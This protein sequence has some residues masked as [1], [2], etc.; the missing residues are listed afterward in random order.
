MSAMGAARRSGVILAALVALGG[1]A[2]VGVMVR[3]ALPVDETRYLAVAWE[4]WRGGDYLTPHLNGA[5]YSHKPPLLFWLI[6]LVWAAWGEVS[7]V[8]ARLVAPGFGLASLLLVWRLS[9]ALWP[10]ARDAAAMAPWVLATTGAFLVFASLTTF[11]AMLTAATLLALLALVWARRGGGRAAWLGFGAALALGVLSKGPV[12]LVHTLPVALLMPLWAE[13]ATRPAPGRW[14]GGV[15]VGVLTGLALTALWLVPAILNGGPEYRDQVLWGQSAGRMVDSFA[16]RQP[17]WFFLALIP[18]FVWPWGWSPLLRA[19]T[20][21]ALWADEG[22]RFC[23][24]QLVAAL[25]IFSAISGKQPHYLLPEIAIVAALVARQVGGAVAKPWRAI[26]LIPVALMA[27]AALAAASGLIPE[28]AL[29]GFFVPIPSALLA[30][31]VSAG[32]ILAVW[33]IRAPAL[34]LGLIA[35]GALAVFYLAGGPSMRALYD[36]TPIA[37]ALAA[38]QAQGLAVIGGRYHGEYGFAGRLSAPVDALYTPEEIAA[39]GLAHPGGAAVARLD[40]EPPDW[41]MVAEALFRAR[42][43]GVFRAPEAAPAA[44]EATEAAPEATEAAPGATEAAPE[45]TEAAPEA[46][47]A[48]PEAT[49]AAPEAT[50]AAPEAMDAAPEATGG[51]AAPSAVEA[52]Q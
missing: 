3:P 32:V 43:Y 12:I 47:E 45:A 38:H 35:P 34:A 6:N 9:R 10:E 13:R 15:G 17:F 29:R 8:A 22:A 20:P 1:A 46:T 11:D 33:S 4:M 39:W 31:A 50:E 51:A 5:V 26:A 14:Y 48:A 44:P 23:A 52:G 40:R 28:A 7:G 27:L 21:R 19:F 2:F 36:A 37:Q 41:P 25:A 30:F 16:H 24:V 18:L 42:A 49:E